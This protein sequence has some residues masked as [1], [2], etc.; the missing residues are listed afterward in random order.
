MVPWLVH[1]SVVVEAADAAVRQIR[2]ALA[3]PALAILLRDVADLVLEF[4]EPAL[5]LLL[6][7]RV[8][9]VDGGLGHG[10]SEGLRSHHGVAII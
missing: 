6:F 9:I 2:V 7:R 5:G 4:E 3:A 10:L 1:E 8:L